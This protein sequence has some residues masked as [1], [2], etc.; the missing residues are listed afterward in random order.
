MDNFYV[1][2]LSMIFIGLMGGASYVNVKYLI[3]ES[4]NLKR[5]E[6]EVALVLTSIGDDLG[7]L[8]A[9]LLALL[10]NN[11]AFKN[12]WSTQYIKDDLH[13]DSNQ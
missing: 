7:I 4:P 13:Y 1:L 11:T 5:T 2:F 6:K 12:M 3:L 8:C 9:A 10:L